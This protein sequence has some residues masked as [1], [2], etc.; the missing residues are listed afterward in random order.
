MMRS[1]VH[2]RFAAL[3]KLAFVAAQ[4]VDDKQPNNSGSITRYTT[5]AWPTQTRMC[6]TV[7]AFVHPNL[8]A[9]VTDRLVFPLPKICCPIG[10]DSRNVQ[11]RC[12]PEERRYYCL[13]RE[14]GNCIAWRRRH[15]PAISTC[16]MSRVDHHPLRNQECRLVSPGL[17]CCATKK[18]AEFCLVP[19]AGKM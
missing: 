4:P 2:L 9:P 13:M 11:T 1:V 16:L 5:A 19:R 6:R 18:Y 7:I 3:S 14:T 17:R 10:P 15:T 12:A 8:P